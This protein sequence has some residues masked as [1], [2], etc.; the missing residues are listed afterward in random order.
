MVMLLGISGLQAKV[1]SQTELLELKVN[2]ATMVEAIKQLQEKTQSGGKW[3]EWLEKQGLA[4]FAPLWQSVDIEAGWET[5]LEVVLAERMR[6]LEISSLE[7]AAPFADETMP[8][9]VC[10][11]SVTQENDAAKAKESSR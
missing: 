5:A 1:W 7:R 10:F 6:A 9:K 4:G 2:N 3:H 11:F 8:A